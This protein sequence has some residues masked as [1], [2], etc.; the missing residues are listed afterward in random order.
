MNSQAGMQSRRNAPA[1]IP[2]AAKL[3]QA[4]KAR[5]TR[6]EP[7]QSISKVFMPLIYNKLAAVKMG[8]IP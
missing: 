2:P 4:K 7:L 3:I 8:Y 5:I 1:R 6:I